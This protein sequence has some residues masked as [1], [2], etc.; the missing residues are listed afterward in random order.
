[1]VRHYPDGCGIGE[2]LLDAS[3]DAR[4]TGDVGCNRLRREEGPAA[5]G[6]LR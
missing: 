4:F 5:A 1:M 3:R 2:A 6:G